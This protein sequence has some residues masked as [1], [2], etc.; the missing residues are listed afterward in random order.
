MSNFAEEATIISRAQQ[1]RP[2][3]TGHTELFLAQSM[4]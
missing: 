1:A 3:V 2:K 4:I